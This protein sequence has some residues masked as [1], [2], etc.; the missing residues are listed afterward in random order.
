MAPLFSDRLFI[1]DLDDT[2]ANTTRDMRGSWENLPQLTLAPGAHQFVRRY[3]ERTVLLTAGNEEVQLR[4][5]A[6][7]GLKGILRLEIVVPEPELKQAALESLLASCALPPSRFVIIGDRLDKEIA[8]GNRLGF[9]TVRMRLPHG[10]WGAYEPAS[11]EERPHA[12]IETFDELE[13]ALLSL[14][15]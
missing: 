13:G 9:V 5:I 4:K 1:V 12:T 3:G 2:L 11:E 7:L 6:H 14:P 15:Y 10:R 8:A